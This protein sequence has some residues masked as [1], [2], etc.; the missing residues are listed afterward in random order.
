MPSVERIQIICGSDTELFQA[1]CKNKR[2]DDRIKGK[3]CI[4]NILQHPE[5]L[6]RFCIAI[7]RPF[8]D[9]KLGSVCQRLNEMYMLTLQTQAKNAEW[10][11]VARTLRS[12]SEMP[13]SHYCCP[14]E[15]QAHIKK[16][17]RVVP[18]ALFLAGLFSEKGQSAELA[19]LIYE[20]GS[21]I[22][23]EL[24]GLFSQLEIASGDKIVDSHFHSMKLDLQNHYQTL[25]T[26]CHK[27][28]IA[29]QVQYQRDSS[30]VLRC[31]YI[32]SD[33]L[34]N[35]AY[36]LL[37]VDETIPCIQFLHRIAFSLF[38]EPELAKCYTSC[39]EKI[40]SVDCP[41][42]DMPLAWAL[43]NTSHYLQG[44]KKDDTLYSIPNLR[45]GRIAEELHGRHKVIRLMGPGQVLHRVANPVFLM[46]LQ[47]MENR[48]FTPMVH[49]PYPYLGQSLINMQD[50]IHPSER[51]SSVQLMELGQRYPFSLFACTIG[52]ITPDAG[53]SSIVSDGSF[54]LTDE[55]KGRFYFPPSEKER[56]QRDF[57]LIARWV[58]RIVPNHN[59][60][61]K[62]AAYEL[63]KLGMWFYFDIRAIR[64]F[65]DI[66]LPH[67]QDAAILA[68]QA[69]FSGVDRAGS[70]HAVRLSACGIDTPTIA[71][72]FFGRAICC[73][74]RPP[75]C[76]ERV[77]LFATDV[78]LD[79][80]QL[81]VKWVCQL[82]STD[83]NPLAIELQKLAIG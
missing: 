14:P 67:I 27:I 22:I 26:A 61:G 32:L 79:Q 43:H 51:E 56:W 20:S 42:P 63:L 48:R 75:N 69:C 68:L 11:A 53:W 29:T 21:P 73:W 55:N 59:T 47:A 80:C 49:D 62:I 17:E 6:G 38:S 76:V 83:D 31:E 10:A 9:A 35:P 36:A 33:V 1:L 52:S 70:G 4:D 72:L 45:T 25:V 81:F 65:H 44:L 19:K 71:K 18:H 58:E 3:E 64:Y 41:T 12:A 66:P 16:I 15:K 39:V 37:S 7:S 57:Q 46:V 54:L 13:L 2:L 50:L 78:P 60:E 77:K 40:L 34:Q 74:G 23:D 28:K 30:V 8:S 82:A 24:K 5:L